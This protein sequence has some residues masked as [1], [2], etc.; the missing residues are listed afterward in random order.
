LPDK[1]F[2]AIAAKLDEL[3]RLIA[4]A[5]PAAATAPDFAAADAFVWLPGERRLQPVASALADQHARFDQAAHA[6]FEEKGIALGECGKRLKECSGYQAN[7][8]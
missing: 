1:D 8:I 5:V 7:A 3:V 2:N 4:R 6:F